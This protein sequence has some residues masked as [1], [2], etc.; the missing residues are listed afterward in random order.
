MGGFDR[1]RSQ[2]L[3]EIPD[4]YEVQAVVAIGHQA[5]RETLPEDLQAREQPSPRIP[6]QRL[7]AAGRFNPDTL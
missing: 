1:E 6:L 3:L 7:A 2:T 5:A 4:D